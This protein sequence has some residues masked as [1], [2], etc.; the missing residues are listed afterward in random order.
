M[1]HIMLPE[2]G[3]RVDRPGKYADTAVPLLV[4][5]LVALGCKNRSIIAKMAGGACM[6]EYFGTNLNIGERNAEKVRTLL[7]EYHIQLGAEDVGGKSR[8]IGYVFARPT[9]D[10]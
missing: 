9:V 10:G 7:E 8:A 2:S 6:F 3:G 4:G 1:V 5:E